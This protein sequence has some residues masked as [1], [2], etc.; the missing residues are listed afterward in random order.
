MAENLIW[1]AETK[2]KNRKIIVWA[3]SYHIVKEKQ[4]LSFNRIDSKSVEL[5]GNMVNLRMP[6]QVYSLNFIGGSGTY[7]EWFKQEYHT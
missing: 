3:A 5:L 4:E 1:L 2:F 7:G 6:G